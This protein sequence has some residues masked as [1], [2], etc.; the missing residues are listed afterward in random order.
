MQEEYYY[1]PV[2]MLVQ[3]PVKDH[4]DHLLRMMKETRADIEELLSIHGPNHPL[5]Y[6]VK[7]KYLQC[8]EELISHLSKETIAVLPYA[9][10]YTQELKK[11]SWLRKPGQNSVCYF[12]DAMYN[13][14][15]SGKIY[16]N[17]IAELMKLVDLQDHVLHQNICITLEE[18]NF[19]WQELVRLEN[20]ILFPKLVEME[21]RLKPI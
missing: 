5:L 18:M 12:I 19:C 14:H 4:H 16:F 1:W 15:K 21:A 13:E 2:D 3:Y 17:G 11:H 8:T 9:K 6:E 7:R 10:K 20:D